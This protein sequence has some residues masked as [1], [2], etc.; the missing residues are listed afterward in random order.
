MKERDEGQDGFLTNL[1]KAKKKGVK[2]FKFPRRK[3]DPS[4][5]YLA[6]KIY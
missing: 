5:S 2:A 1:E 6:G 3:P 4:R